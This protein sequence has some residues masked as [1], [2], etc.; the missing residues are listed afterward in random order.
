MSDPEA[1]HDEYYAHGWVEILHR[2]DNLPEP[3]HLL[4]LIPQQYQHVGSILPLSEY[5]SPIDI[6]HQFQ[7]VEDLEFGIPRALRAYDIINLCSDEF[8]KI[9]TLA[10]V[11]GPRVND[12]IYPGVAV[13][14]TSLLPLSML[15][16]PKIFESFYMKQQER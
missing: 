11:P 6:Y 4:D 14:R 3:K 7:E 2:K 1:S 5:Y 16:R 9:V 10:L 13:Q 8:N 15:T 12:L